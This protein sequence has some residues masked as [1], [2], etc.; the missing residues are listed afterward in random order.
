MYYKNKM[1]SILSVSRSEFESLKKEVE[2]LKKIAPEP[3]EPRE[4][5]KPSEYNMHVSREISKIRLENPDINHQTAFKKAAE[6]WT[7]AKT[8]PAPAPIPQQISIVQIA[9]PNAQA[10]VKTKSRSKT[11]QKA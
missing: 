8:A 6:S 9:D 7:K 10:Q 3:K 1:E 5:R 4:P 2:S 11:K